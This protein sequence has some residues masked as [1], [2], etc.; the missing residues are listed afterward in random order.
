MLGLIKEFSR[1]LPLVY[2][3]LFTEFSLS[4]KFRTTLK[5]C[6]QGSEPG[7]Q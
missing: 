3:I 1:S 4:R 6:L 2:E 5:A 7:G